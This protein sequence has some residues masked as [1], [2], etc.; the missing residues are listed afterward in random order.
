MLDK[1]MADYVAGKLS[2]QDVVERI[3]ISDGLDYGSIIQIMYL[4]LDDKG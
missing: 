3:K 2:V 4:W 1:I